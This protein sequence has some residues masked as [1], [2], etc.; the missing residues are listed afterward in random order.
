MKLVLSPKAVEDLEGI[1]DFIARDNPE[2]ALSLS[3]V[4][5]FALNGSFTAHGGFLTSSET[6]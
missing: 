6:L 5:L 4:T 1:G 3:R 2:R